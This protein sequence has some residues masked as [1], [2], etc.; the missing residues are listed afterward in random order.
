MILMKKSWKMLRRKMKQLKS[1][2]TPSSFTV[3][4]VGSMRLIDAKRPALM[5]MQVSAVKV[6]V[7]LPS[8][9]ASKANLSSVVKALKMQAPLAA[10]RALVLVFLTAR[11]VW[12]VSNTLLAK[13]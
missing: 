9:V 12:V 10:T 3:E 6:K 8:Q 13:V 7:A 1:P 4:R 5:V 11:K 2:H